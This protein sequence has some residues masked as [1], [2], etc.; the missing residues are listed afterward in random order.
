MKEVEIQEHVVPVPHNSNT[1]RSN[2]PSSYV[3]KYLNSKQ[4][5]TARGM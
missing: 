1:G 2:H 4:N 3:E 5:R